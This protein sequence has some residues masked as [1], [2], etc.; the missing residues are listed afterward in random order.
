MPKLTVIYSPMCFACQLH[1]RWDIAREYGY[2]VEEVSI[3][4]IRAG[5]TKVR[6]TVCDILDK[7]DEQGGFLF[8]P[9][10]VFED[11]GRAM[12]FFEVAR[13]LKGESR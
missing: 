7:M 3:L 13:Y 5:K 12:P 4:D 10:A 6:P 1:M 9:L 8:G 2:E 11:E